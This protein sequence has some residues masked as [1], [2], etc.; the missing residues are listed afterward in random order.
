MNNPK[1]RET[2]LI[3]YNNKP[4]VQY[5]KYTGNPLFEMLY[6]SYRNINPK[7]HQYPAFSDIGS[8]NNYEKVFSDMYSWY[9]KRY[10]DELKLKKGGRGQKRYV[11]ANTKQYSFDL[12]YCDDRQFDA[13]LLT[14][15]PQ[16]GNQDLFCFILHTAVA[17]MVDPTALDEVLKKLGFHPL[18][19]RNIHHLAVY[20]VLSDAQ[21]MKRALP[22]DYN[23]FR[24]VKQL[25]DEA[26]TI[27]SSTPEDSL[28]IYTYENKETK[29]IREWVFTNRGLSKENFI[30]IVQQNKTALNMRHSLIMD[31]FH[32]LSSVYS[33]ILTDPE[34]DSFNYSFFQ[35]INRFCNGV[36]L[37]KF[38]E[39]MHNTID[40]DTG[41]QIKHPTRQ[42]LILLWLYDF[43]FSFTKGVEMTSAEFK[44]MQDLLSKHHLEWAKDAENYYSGTIF[45]PCGFINGRQ[46]RDIR[47][48]FDGSKF[49]S[50]IDNKLYARYGWGTLNPRLPFDY[51]ILQLHKLYISYCEEYAVEN[52]GSISWGTTLLANTYAGVEN[53]PRSLVV[54][55]DIMGE[56]EELIKEKQRNLRP[57]ITER[58]Q[59]QEPEL[60]KAE[61]G[62]LSALFSVIPRKSCDIIETTP[63]NLRHAIKDTLYLALKEPE[64]EI[65]KETDKRTQNI[66]SILLSN[67]ETSIHF[68][69]KHM[70]TSD[71]AAVP[72]KYKGSLWE[73]TLKKVIDSLS[74][75]E[76]ELIEFTLEVL[77]KVV[78]DVIRKE[79][80]EKKNERERETPETE[81]SDFVKTTR[82][83]FKVKQEEQKLIMEAK[84]RT[85][86]ILTLILVYYSPV[87]KI[88]QHSLDTLLDAEARIS[89]KNR[90]E[91]EIQKELNK[92]ISPFFL[93]CR[94][95]EQI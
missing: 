45:D 31:D 49:I 18:H 50:W 80:D 6:D 14:E 91:E 66:L 8:N 40:K 62:K 81:Y 72:S 42:I 23:P 78:R 24:E 54:I 32:K 94:I 79:R 19:V 10:Q 44:K 56:V 28:E 38:K 60:Y 83:K 37:K 89:T 65:E 84:K 47:A 92:K 22:N 87:I 34:M 86:G 29:E 2:A 41:T 76:S 57:L 26:N 30:R 52:C 82:K 67:N 77:E 4:N 88:D 51:Y 17:F 74:Q 21:K 64:K 63:E 9:T 36:S 75:S 20:T 3:W 61:K 39:H 71:T 46:N 90:M 5:G 93:D 53:V 11:T 43:C 15:T 85:P 13:Y 95:Y 27:L 48:M 69:K 59:H 33:S 25:Y 70:I 16:A 7:G 35:F 68:N 58:V 12:L 1:F 73:K 55:T